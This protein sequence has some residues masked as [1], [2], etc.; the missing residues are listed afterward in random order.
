MSI[1]IVL[2]QH[3]SPLQ[4]VC[5][6]TQ[7]VKVS[8]EPNAT[9]K[10]QVRLYLTANTC[11]FDNGT[12]DLIQEVEATTPSDKSE[13]VFKVNIRCTLSQM[14]TIVLNAEATNS[15]GESFDDSITTK[16]NCRAG[17][18][19]GPAINEAIS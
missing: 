19:A 16:I 6:V 8:V 5:G 9:G 12:K 15:P 1:P 18:S 2:F 3:E 7:D 10:C 17:E 4:L 14:Y 13:C 11:N